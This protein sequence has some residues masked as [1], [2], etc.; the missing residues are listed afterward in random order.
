ML[1]W[2]DKESSERRS[3]KRIRGEKEWC[4]SGGLE[5]FARVVGEKEGVTNGRSG[6]MGAGWDKRE[7]RST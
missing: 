1:P 3:R 7:E 2:L 5:V 4:G 6:W